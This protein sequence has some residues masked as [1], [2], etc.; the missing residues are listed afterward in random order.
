MLPEGAASAITWESS[1]E[2]VLRVNA[3]EGT[4]Y[5]VKTGKATLTAINQYGVFVVIVY[6][7]AVTS[8]VLFFSLR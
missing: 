6:D 3:Q 2:K 4:M 1:N 5:G 7:C 8:A